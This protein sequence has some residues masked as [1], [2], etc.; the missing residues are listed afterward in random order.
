M[1]H[2]HFGI[3][4]QII[5]FATKVQKNMHIRKRASIIC[6]KRLSAYDILYSSQARLKGDMEDWMQGVHDF[7]LSICMLSFSSHLPI[8]S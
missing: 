1:I 5:K 8:F 7:L 2:C 3:F 6:K 4:M